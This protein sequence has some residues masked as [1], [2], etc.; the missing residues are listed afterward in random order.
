MY[1]NDRHLHEVVSL[2]LLLYSY[3]PEIPNVPQLC[4]LLRAIII[5]LADRDIPAP[6]LERILHTVLPG[7]DITGIEFLAEGFRNANFKLGF[8]DRNDVMVLRIYQHDPALCQKE[9]DLIRRLEKTCSSAGTD[10]CGRLWDPA[11][12]SAALCRGRDVSRIETERRQACHRA[13][14]NFRG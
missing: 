1:V 2:I 14:G 11:V 13:G 5:P 12:Y 7:C 10:L 3:D 9:I 4:G 6:I 8:G